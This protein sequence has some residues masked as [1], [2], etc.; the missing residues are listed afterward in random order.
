MPK[1]DKQGRLKIPFDF[2]TRL[3]S[4]NNK[5]IAICYDI[6]RIILLNSNQTNNAKIIAFRKIDE[7]GR[8]SLPKEAF[9][10]M[11]ATKNSTFIV[12]SQNLNIYIEA[13]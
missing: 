12:Y 3:I 7:K 2:R 9:S 1:L 11:N 10:I 4:Q 5:N 6:S 8:I 13:L